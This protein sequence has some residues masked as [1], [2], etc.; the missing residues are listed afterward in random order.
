M[1]SHFSTSFLTILIPFSLLKLYST[2]F[3]S[4]SAP[5]PL[6][7]MVRIYLTIRKRPLLSFSYL[8]GLTLPYALIFVSSQYSRPFYRV[9]WIVT[10]LD[11]G[12]ATAMN[13][14]PKW[15]R[16]IAS[17]LFSFYYLIYAQEADEKLRKFRAFCTVDMMRATWH[18]TTNPYIRLVTW[19]HRPSLG[20]AR[21]ILL[22]RPKI[23][24]HNK[25]PTKAW[26]F[27]N[28]SEKQLRE[29]LEV[30]FLR[31]RKGSLCC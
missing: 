18:K 15:L 1:I 22:P 12:F 7:R 2:L 25:R 16:D 3:P 8:F 21:E 29:E 4:R 31:D 10:A 6:A 17:L 27:Y 19:F 13:I 20:I 11:A 9:T 26:L 30:S 24:P 28:G 14:Q 23:G 5:E